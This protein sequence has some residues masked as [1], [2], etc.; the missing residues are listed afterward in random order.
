M[1]TNRACDSL[2]KLWLLHYLG[3]RT[4]KDGI[5]G[6][7]GQVSQAV[8]EDS[9]KT[10]GLCDLMCELGDYTVHG[11]VFVSSLDSQRVVLVG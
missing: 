2:V 10:N 3:C 1:A 8:Q 6:T 7:C 9:D 11:V 5:G 4:E